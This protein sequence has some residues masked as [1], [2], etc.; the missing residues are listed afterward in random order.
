MSVGS[1]LVLLDHA[2]RDAGRAVVFA[3]GAA[4][5]GI[6]PG[7]AATATRPGV[8]FL[9]SL[10]GAAADDLIARMQAVRQPGDVAVVS[11]HWGSNW[12][13]GVAGDQIRFAHRLIDGEV[14]LICGHSSHHPRP[15]EVYRGRLV[16][17]HNR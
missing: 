13:Y 1:G 17:P 16:L 7:W 4:S 14:D 15:V 2:C 11:I 9:P 10:S 8:A 6:P 5:S 12:G 3:C